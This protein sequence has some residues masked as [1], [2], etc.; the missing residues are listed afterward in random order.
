MANEKVV[1]G[2]C[3]TSQ[4]GASLFAYTENNKSKL[5]IIIKNFNQKAIHTEKRA[6]KH[7]NK[8][9]IATMLKINAASYVQ[10]ELGNDILESEDCCAAHLPN[11]TALRNLKQ[12]ENEKSFHD[13]D[14]IKSLCMLKKDGLFHNFITNIRIDPFYCFMATPEQREWLWLST[15]FKKC[16]VSIDSTG[17]QIHSIPSQTYV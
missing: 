10:V 12:R 5:K 16:I 9:K 13:P 3:R 8:E 4:C 11:K 1:F 2:N 17:M 15:R 7:A 14:P 6:M